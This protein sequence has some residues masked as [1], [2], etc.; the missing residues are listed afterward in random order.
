MDQAPK[1]RVRAPH[2]PYTDRA[3]GLLNPVARNRIKFIAIAI[4]LRQNR[5]DI[6]YPG[7]TPFL[8]KRRVPGRKSV[9]AVAEGGF[10]SRPP[11]RVSV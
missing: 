6:P 8:L 4:R 5:P 9:I 11:W 7:N 2:T 10:P 1:C 3:M